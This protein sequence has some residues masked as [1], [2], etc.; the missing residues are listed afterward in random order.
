MKKYRGLGY[1]ILAIAGAFALSALITFGL[2]KGDPQAIVEFGL[3]GRPRRSDV[4]YAYPAHVSIT[5]AL[6]YATALALSGVAHIRGSRTWLVI[7]GVVGL[8]AAVWS[9]IGGIRFGVD[10]GS[11]WLAV[12]VAAVTIALACVSTIQPLLSRGGRSR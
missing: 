1:V 10:D 6:A 11:T 3:P 7:A 8:L 5:A 2:A 12:L 4:T 9:A